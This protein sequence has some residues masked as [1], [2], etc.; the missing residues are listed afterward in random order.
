MAD[1]RFRMADIYAMC[2]YSAAHL[3]TAGPEIS[4]EFKAQVEELADTSFELSRQAYALGRAAER[5][6]DRSIDRERML[7]PRMSGA[8]T[9]EMEH[10]KLEMRMIAKS[11]FKQKG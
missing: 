9:D 11:V 4:S 8:D 3:L 10:F 1:E 6:K 2:A 7:E 5:S